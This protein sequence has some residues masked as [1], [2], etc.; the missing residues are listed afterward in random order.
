[1][2]ITL[3]AKNVK[4]DVTSCKAIQGNLSTCWYA[5][6]TWN[7]GAGLVIPTEMSINTPWFLECFGVTCSGFLRLHRHFEKWRIALGT[8]LIAYP[9]HYPIQVILERSSTLSVEGNFAIAMVMHFYALWLT[10]KTRATLSTNQK[11]MSK[12]KTNR[13]LPA[14]RFS[15]LGAGYMYLLRV[16]IGLLNCLRLFWFYDTQ[17]KTALLAINRDWPCAV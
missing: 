3:Y 5:V 10:K 11:W 16:L 1:M 6:K 15:G 9:F 8:S 17:V 2:T 4:V 14:R 12:T 7:G 13:N